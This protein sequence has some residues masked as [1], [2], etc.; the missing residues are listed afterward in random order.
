[1]PAVPPLAVHE[2][3][4]QAVQLTVLAE[5]MLDTE[6]TRWDIPYSHEKEDSA[7][8][9]IRS[10]SPVFEMAHSDHHE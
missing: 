7:V 6:H 8:L 3:I 1:M 2:N 5:E 10:T 9:L 4:P